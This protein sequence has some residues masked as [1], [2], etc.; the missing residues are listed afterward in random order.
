MA[1][2]TSTIGSFPKPAALHTARQRFAEGEIDAAALRA[3]EDEAT[4]Q[5]VEAQ[6][7]LGITLVVDGEMDRADP[8]TTFAERLAGVEIDGWVR[9][10]GDRYARRAKIVGPLART[11]STTVERWRVAHD[12]ARGSV[13]AVLPGPYSLMDASFDKHYSSRR[14]ACLAFASIVRDEA[15]DLAIAGA[16][17]IQLD[18]PSAGARPEEAALLREALTIVTAPL[19]GRTRV[20]V[21]AGYADLAAASPALA[22]L[23]AD[24]LLVAGAH[25]GYEG[26]AALAAAVPKDREFGIGVIDVL[27]PRIESAAE[28]RERADVVARH[29]PRERIWLVPDGGFRALRPA[30]AMGKLEALAAAATS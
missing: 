19:Q 28:I 30:T 14:E 2:L 16:A 22:A 13:K 17:E 26:L 12:A 18:E 24:G 21:Y 5:V 25:C 15:A 27:D 11:S 3:L 23:P 6:D 4:R 29:L 10:Y 8:I 7:A 20:W 9:I 1:F